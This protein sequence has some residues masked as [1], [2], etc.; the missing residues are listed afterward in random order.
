MIAGRA[1][2]ASPVTMPANRDDRDPHNHRLSYEITHITPF[3]SGPF[4]NQKG[5]RD[6]PFPA[7]TLRRLAVTI[8]THP[9]SASFM[10]S[11]RV[12]VLYRVPAGVKRGAADP[13]R[14]SSRSRR[15]QPVSHSAAKRQGAMLVCG[16]GATSAWPTGRSTA[17]RMTQPSG[18][19]QVAH[20][21]ERHAAVWTP[22]ETP[23]TTAPWTT[24]WTISPAAAGAAEMACRPGCMSKII[25]RSL[26]LRG[27]AVGCPTL[28]DFFAT[29]SDRPRACC[30]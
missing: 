11:P 24:S 21:P 17:R 5:H 13:A 19:I 6:Q 7:P 30:F 29:D 9:A 14:L 20:A 2:E 15:L 1:A 18:W 16:T 4:L 10:P 23:L 28:A 27:R 12:A 26:M 25:Y 3:G 8:D 22:G